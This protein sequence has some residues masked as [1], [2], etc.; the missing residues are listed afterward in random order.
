M[1]KTEEKLAGQSREGPPEDLMSVGGGVRW[2]KS[3][4]CVVREA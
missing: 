3:R 4:G 2:K 1:L